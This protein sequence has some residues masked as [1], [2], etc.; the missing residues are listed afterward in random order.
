MWNT[1]LL[2]SVSENFDINFVMKEFTAGKQSIIWWINV[3]NGTLNRQETKHKRL[4]LADEKSDDTGA[5]LEH[6]PRKS[7]KRL[8]QET[9]ASES[10]ARSWTQFLKL[11]TYKPP[12]IHALQP[13]DLARGVH[14]CS[15]FL[16]SVGEGE[17][18]PQ[19]I[20]YSDEAWFNLQGYINTQTK[21]IGFYR[22]HNEPT[23]ACCIQWKLV[24]DVM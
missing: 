1:D 21:S 22:I 3:D 10:S 5:R 13:S 20:L 9:G 7:L 14:F 4:V 18:D 15:W 16:Q 17:I 12:V 2:E 8:A 24:S 11:K 6:T 19:L 23:K